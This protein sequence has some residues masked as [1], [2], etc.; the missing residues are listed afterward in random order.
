MV[1]YVLYDRKLA[2]DYR[3]DGYIL[4]HLPQDEGVMS[5]KGANWLI[6]INANSDICY[7]NDKV[8]GPF[9]LRK[10]PF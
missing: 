9:L 3:D 1:A 2:S 6:A 5:P 10:A 4:G 7:H 8:V